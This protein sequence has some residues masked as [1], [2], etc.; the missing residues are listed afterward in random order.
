[1]MFMITAATI[2]E[3]MTIEIIENPTQKINYNAYQH[4]INKYKPTLKGIFERFEDDVFGTH[5]NRRNRE[6]FIDKLTQEGWKYFLVKNLN[7]L[8]AITFKELGM[9][10]DYD[11]NII[12][13]DADPT[14]I[15]DSKHIEHHQ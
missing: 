1:M 10:E 3:Q 11:E 2:L 12:L 9:D 6:T 13:S 5:Y 4:K 15:A 14:A 7:E 8:F